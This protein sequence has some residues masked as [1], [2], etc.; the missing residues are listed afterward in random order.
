MNK[1]FVIYSGILVSYKKEH[2]WVISNSKW[3]NLEPNVPSEVT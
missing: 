3:I 2:I 1:E